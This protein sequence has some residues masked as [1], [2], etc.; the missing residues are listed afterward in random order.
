[1][2]EIRI[3]TYLAIALFFARKALKKVLTPVPKAEPAVDNIDI[4][5]K[6]DMPLLP[7]TSDAV[8]AIVSAWTDEVT[9]EIDREIL[10]KMCKQLHEKRDKTKER[11]KR[12]NEN[13]I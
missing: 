7:S 8:N 3:A 9:A 6:Y 13:L 1:M 4:V 12:I 5:Q 2:R 11:L 10:H